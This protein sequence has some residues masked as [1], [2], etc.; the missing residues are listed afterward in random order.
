MY[1]TGWNEQENGFQIVFPRF[2][3]LTRTT[4]LIGVPSFLTGLG[5]A[6]SGGR[7]LFWFIVSLFGLVKVARSM[8]NVLVK[9]YINK[10]GITYSLLYLI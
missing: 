10:Y 6:I 5:G 9:N 3:E 1:S 8:I 4:F 7:T 2:V